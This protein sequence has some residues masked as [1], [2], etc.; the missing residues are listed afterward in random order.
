[1]L[2]RIR[3]SVARD[4]SKATTISLTID[5][6]SSN[7]NTHSLLAVTAHF[8]EEMRPTYR[9]LSAVPLKVWESHINI[10]NSILT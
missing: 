2:Q 4:V 9:I 1:M 3:E 5:G 7:E 8:L 10:Y 6:W